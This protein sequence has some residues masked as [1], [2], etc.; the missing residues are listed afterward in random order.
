MIISAPSLYHAAIVRFI[1]H[2]LHK[3]IYELMMI[4]LHTRDRAVY[5]RGHTQG[6]M[7]YDGISPFEGKTWCRRAADSL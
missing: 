2:A 6:T 3:M 4:I 5:I 7:I 1:K